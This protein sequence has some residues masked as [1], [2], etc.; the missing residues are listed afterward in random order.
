MD[1]IDSIVRRLPLWFGAVDAVNE[2][3]ARELGIGVSDLACVHELVV[4]GPLP[5]GELARRLRLTTGAVSHMI[6]RLSA[7]GLVTR[8]RV[9]S[10]RRRVD[11]QIVPA[12]RDRALQ[13]YARLNEQVRVTLSGFTAAEL[14]VIDR[15]ISQC[16]A[17]TLV[18]AET[19]AVR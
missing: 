9:E 12:A 4:D 18:L 7:T 16:L 6:D 8:S 15:F 13:G 1:G 2:Q 3:A 19:E 17:D 10:D 14:A 11:V 5:A